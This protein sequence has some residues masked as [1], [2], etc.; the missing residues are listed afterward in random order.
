MEYVD[1]KTLI[2]WAKFYTSAGIPIAF[3]RPTGANKAPIYNIVDIEPFGNVM[4]CDNPDDIAF[5]VDPDLRNDWCVAF[6]VLAKYFH[7]FPLK[8][9]RREMGDPRTQP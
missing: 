6:E 1:K 3:M 9:P 5:M 7:G 4:A 2:D 8:F